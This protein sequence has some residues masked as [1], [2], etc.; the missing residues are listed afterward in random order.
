MGRSG[1][2]KKG[3]GKTAG[4]MRWVLTVSLMGMDVAMSRNI[5]QCSQGPCG[6]GDDICSGPSPPQYRFHLSDSSCSINDLN[7]PFYDPLHKVYHA[8][9]QRH[10]AMPDRTGH[11]AAQGPVWGHWTS[12]DM[13]SWSQQPT[14]LW[15]DQWYD[16]A[17]VFSG[18]AS[19]VNGTPIIIS[20]VGVRVHVGLP[21]LGPTTLTTLP[22][23]QTE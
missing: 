5:T 4:I 11:E 13:V 10:L 19:V 1:S 17:A 9:Y 20:L 6:P 15:N 7:G 14:A 12:P 16:N 18:S 21:P 22:L 2:N 23:L 3:E 8:F